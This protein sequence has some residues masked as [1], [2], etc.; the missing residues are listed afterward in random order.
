MEMRPFAVDAAGEAHQGNSWHID[1]PSIGQN[2]SHD[3]IHCQ[4][5]RRKVKRVDI[6]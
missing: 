6:W 3:L 1:S 2:L 4:E 5:L